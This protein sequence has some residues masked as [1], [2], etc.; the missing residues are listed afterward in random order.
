M[1]LRLS[2]SMNSHVKGA[3]IIKKHEKYLK[4]NP[5]VLTSEADAVSKVKEYFPTFDD[6]E[7]LRLKK[8]VTINHLRKSLY[9]TVVERE[10]RKHWLY[11]SI[12]IFDMLASSGKLDQEIDKGLRFEPAEYNA[13]KEFLLLSG[14]A[15]EDAFRKGLLSASSAEIDNIKWDVAEKYQDEVDLY[16]D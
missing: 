3:N 14:K 8:G 10:C 16:K 4:R 7:I 2:M 6:S 5:I 15:T 12:E 13:H 1:D 9:K 11:Q